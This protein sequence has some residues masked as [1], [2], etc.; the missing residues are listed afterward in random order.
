ME[1]D[2][3]DTLKLTHC[4][5]FQASCRTSR[6]VMDP[7]P[8]GRWS[9]THTIVLHW[10]REVAASEAAQVAVDESV[11]RWVEERLDA[12]LDVGDA[13]DGRGQLVEA[14]Q[15]PTR[16]LEPLEVRHGQEAHRVRVTGR[17]PRLG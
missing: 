12:A 2:W 5:G 14:Q 10:L 13:R 17:R 7:V 16:R 6:A 3:S 8:G 9:F 4:T 11:S 15:R 1:V